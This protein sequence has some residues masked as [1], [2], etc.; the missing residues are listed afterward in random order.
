MNLIGKKNLYFAISL[1]IIIPGIISFFL[2]GFRLSIDFI[3]GSRIEYQISSVRQAQDK[4]QI[5]NEDIKKTFGEQK[6]ETNSIQKS[7]KDTLIVRTKPIDEKTY[8]KVTDSLKKKY[9]VKELSFQTIGPTI[10]SETTSKAIQAVIIASILIVLYIVWAFRSVPKPASSLRFGICTILALIHDVVL[11]IG[12]FSLLGHFFL[13]EVDSL[14]VTAILT[15]IGFSVHDTIV[16]FDRIRENLRRMPN[17]GF[18]SVVNESIIQTMARSL[19][20]S[21]TVLLV[22]FTMLLFGGE[23]IKWFIIALLVGIT[24]GTYSSIFNA[25]P[26]LVLW[27]EVRAKRAKVS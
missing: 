25:A 10:G 17:L 4:Y 21:L 8:K 1:I 15:I 12:I 5:S 24:S 27:E 23:S 18:S 2:W 19:N 3:G 11:V 6:V 16:V 7:G 20:T 14:F 13:V 22:L 9:Q 26:L